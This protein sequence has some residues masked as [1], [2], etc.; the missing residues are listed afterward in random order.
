MAIER[1][2]LKNGEIR[3]LVRYPDQGKWRT[4]R[5][6]KTEKAASEWLRALNESRR[7]PRPEPGAWPEATMGPL[8][9]SIS[10][11]STSAGLAITF[12]ARNLF[13]SL[14]EQIDD[15]EDST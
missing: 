10:I 1:Y 4:K 9:D 5:G 7:P 13:E 14:K 12:D 2:F 15:E 6:F 3:W 11:D 8:G